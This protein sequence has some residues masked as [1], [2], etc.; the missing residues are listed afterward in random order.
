M[1]R[2][3]SALKVTSAARTESC[4]SLKSKETLVGG[5]QVHSRGSF[6]YQKRAWKFND[7]MSAGP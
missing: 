5:G 4:N 3:A 1:L 7:T 2:L 6:F